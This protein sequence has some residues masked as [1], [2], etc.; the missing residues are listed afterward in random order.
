MVKKSIEV[1]KIPLDKKQVDKPIDFPKMP[2]LYLEL[3]ENKEK[4]KP[5]MVNKEYSPLKNTPTPNIKQPTPTIKQPSPKS[6][7]TP[8][9]THKY[10]SNNKLTPN[11]YSNHSPH[12]PSQLSVSSSNTNLSAPSSIIST[13]EY[14][15]EKSSDILDD[16]SDISNSTKTPKDR[17]DELTSR[18]QELLDDSNDID[19]LENNKTVSKS[20][21]ISPSPINQISLPQISEQ[22]KPTH[23]KKTPPTL[24][25]LESRR[26]HTKSNYIPDVSRLQQYH[27]EDHDDLKR[28]LIFKF[29]LLR[30]SYPDMD[31]STF[32]IHTSY[33]IIK[34][35]YDITLRRL[36][37]DTSVED[38]KEY[39]IF[40]FLAIEFLFGWLFKFNM[41]GYTQQ[42]ILNMN[43]YN[44]LLIELGEK[45]YIPGSSK[46]GVEWRLLALTAIQTVIFILAKLIVDKTGS[47]I[48]NIMKPAKTHNQQTNNNTKMK[49]PS[50]DINNI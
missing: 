37:I 45:T 1:E 22:N 23:V 5:N 24:A 39:L 27:N 47:N 35:E 11:P 41:K 13:K 3:L 18:L 38:Y 12:H 43:K 29:E 9:S 19:I 6:S 33:E 32:T 48:L 31:I 25:E 36:S 42:Q 26:I 30:K 21:N 34:Q 2:R 17:T 40:F 20:V 4:I 10:T 16:Y 28:E 15:Q 44:R 14:K 50:I 7:H 46:W 8:I 49:G